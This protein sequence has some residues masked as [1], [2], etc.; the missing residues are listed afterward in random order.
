MCF[1]GCHH[2]QCSYDSLDERKKMLVFLLCTGCSQLTSC[3]SQ[4]L[5]SQNLQGVGGLILAILSVLLLVV[6]TCSDWLM[7]IRRRQKSAAR[8]VAAKQAKERVSMLERWRKARG[9]A[10]LQ[11][12]RLSR[13]VSRSISRKL[14]SSN[15][16]QQM[17]EEDSENHSPAHLSDL[18][19]SSPQLAH[20]SGVIVTETIQEHATAP[21][22]TTKL[23]IH[24]R[25]GALSSSPF[26]S[27]SSTH[28]PIILLPQRASSLSKQHSS[29]ERGDASDSYVPSPLQP[30]TISS[31]ETSTPLTTNC[32]HHHHHH[33]PPPPPHQLLPIPRKGSHSQMFAYAYGQIEKERAFGLKGQ[34]PSVKDLEPSLLPPKTTTAATSSEQQQYYDDDAMVVV[35]KKRFKISLSFIDL[36]LVLKGS[37]KKILSNVTGKLAPGC[38]TAVMGPSGAGKTMF[39]NALAGKSASFSHTTG[40]VLINGHP[41]SIHCYKRIIGFVPQDDVVHGSL[42]V[43]ENLWFSA[44]YRST[45]A[46][47]S[48]CFCLLHSLVL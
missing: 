48:L 13:K 24:C 9:S 6:Y 41:G 22:G 14:D 1:L 47:L 46:S 11:A 33:H 27:S 26:S 45:S 35:E 8:E 5:R 16:Q 17:T 12:S 15:T 34:S 4:N 42:T 38:I 28:N 44:S 30:T 32:P 21:T 19:F 18:S 2:H 39:L 29:G 37:G 20:H 40:Q 31:G 36:S 3:K 43:E 10:K 7:D 23:E 25:G